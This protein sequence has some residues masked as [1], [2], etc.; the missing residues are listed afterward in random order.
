MTKAAIL[1]RFPGSPKRALA[2]PLAGLAHRA[3]R[4]GGPVQIRRVGGIRLDSQIFD[5]RLDLHGHLSEDHVTD[6]TVTVVHDHAEDRQQL[7]RRNISSLLVCQD[8]VLG[9]RNVLH[10]KRDDAFL[11]KSQMLRNDRD[12]LV[13]GTGQDA[14]RARR[15]AVAPWL[16]GLT[17]PQEA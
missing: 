17:H 9:I 3:G 16:Q 7:V 13:D 14:P 4:P 6:Q 8:G 11:L 12:E 10:D 1:A 2:T 15:R 5:G